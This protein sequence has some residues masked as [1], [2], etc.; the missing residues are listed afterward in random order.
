MRCEAVDDGDAGRDADRS[1]EVTFTLTVKRTER[2]RWEFVCETKSSIEAWLMVPVLV[3][4]DYYAA[5]VS[6]GAS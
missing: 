3:G 2:G 5:C 6:R 1:D 4:G